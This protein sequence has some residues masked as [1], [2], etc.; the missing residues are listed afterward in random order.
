MTADHSSRPRF[1]LIVTALKGWSK[2]GSLYVHISKLKVLQNPKIMQKKLQTILPQSIF[3]LW[4]KVRTRRRKKLPQKPH[5]KNNLART[6]CSVCNDHVPFRCRQ[7][8]NLGNINTTK[9][10]CLCKHVTCR[11]GPAAHVSVM[12]K[13][14]Q[15][16][17]LCHIC[18]RGSNP[19]T[20]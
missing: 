11:G 18:H 12:L 16:L 13:P 8:T 20:V 1:N 2:S 6:W 17:C 7:A 9:R 5:D 14:W 4:A 19:T 3:L 10:F 15:G